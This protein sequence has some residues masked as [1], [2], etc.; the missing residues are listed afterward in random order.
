MILDYEGAR[1]NISLELLSKTFSFFEDFS[2]FCDEDVVLPREAGT[3]VDIAAAYQLINEYNENPSECKRSFDVSF[4]SLAS[5]ADFLGGK[6]NGH[7]FPVC[8]LKE[9]FETTSISSIHEFI[10]LHVPNAYEKLSIVHQP[11]IR[12]KSVQSS[13]TKLWKPNVLL[14][15]VLPCLIRANILSSSYDFQLPT[16]AS[17]E[18]ISMRNPTVKLL[19]DI[20]TP[21]QLEDAQKKWIEQNEPLALEQS[22]NS[23]FVAIQEERCFLLGN[24][25]KAKR[26]ELSSRRRLDEVKRESLNLFKLIQEPNN[27]MEQFMLIGVYRSRPAFARQCVPPGSGPFLHET[28]QSFSSSNQTLLLNELARLDNKIVKRNSQF[29]NVQGKVV[30]CQ[31]AIGIL[32]EWLMCLV[33]AAATTDLKRRF[34]QMTTISFQLKLIAHV[35]ID[36]FSIPQSCQES[37]VTLFFQ[38]YKEHSDSLHLDLYERIPCDFPKGCRHSNG[39]PSPAKQIQLHDSEGRC[40]VMPSGSQLIWRCGHSMTQT[41]QAIMDWNANI[42]VLVHTRE[43]GVRGL[44]RVAR[45]G[46][47]GG[48]REG[49]FPVIDNCKRKRINEPTANEVDEIPMHL[50]WF[51]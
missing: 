4:L 19:Y 45:C 30:D 3:H 32:D 8:I 25:E 29:L 17:V 50:R 13:N 31:E 33:D 6:F 38:A 27:G 44:H 11:A 1:V 37:L 42:D 48:G 12:N 9:W 7:S 2:S 40:V 22:I 41:Q 34:F 24:I 36:S 14:P 39:K 5:S 43:E 49:T 23:M 51:V 16:F 18:S 10:S 46:Y 15:P 47:H 21:S 26:A 35:I 28:P 20:L